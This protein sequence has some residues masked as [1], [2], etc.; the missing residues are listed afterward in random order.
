MSSTA[1]LHCIVRPTLHGIIATDNWH[2][3]YFLLSPA[4][5]CCSSR[6]PPPAIAAAIL[7]LIAIVGAN[8]AFFIV[9]P[10]LPLMRRRMLAD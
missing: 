10:V 9:T 3:Y 8:I 4:C 2:C 5:S 1:Q 6:C 7:G